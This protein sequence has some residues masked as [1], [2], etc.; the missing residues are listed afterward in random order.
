MMD[1]ISS[2][3]ESSLNKRRESRGHAMPSSVN[4]ISV[5]KGKKSAPPAPPGHPATNRVKQNEEAEMVEVVVNSET[6]RYRMG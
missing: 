4:P 5:A 2:E 3:L 6:E 1:Q